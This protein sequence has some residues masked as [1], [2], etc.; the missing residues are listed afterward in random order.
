MAVELAA[1]VPGVALINCLSQKTQP[2]IQKFQLPPKPDLTKAPPKLS[3]GVP[4]DINAFA[5]QLGFTYDAWRR[6]CVLQHICHRCGGRYD[7]SHLDVLRCP[8]DKKSQLSRTQILNIWRNWGGHVNDGRD[9]RS[10]TPRG[11]DSQL[12]SA[13]D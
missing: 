12:V 8:V 13:F 6:E 4:M 10:E 9:N 11:S 7:S 1:D 5:A 2:I 3:D